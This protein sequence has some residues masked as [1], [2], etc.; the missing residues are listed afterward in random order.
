M[1][2][3]RIVPRLLLPG[4]AVLSL[5]ACMHG[6][7]RPATLDLSRSRLTTHGTYRATIRPEQDTIPQG[8]LHRWILTL[9]TPDGAAVDGATV[10]INGGMPEHGHGLPT[11]PRVTRA[12]GN[13]EHLVEGVK[14]SMRGWWELRFAISTAAGA[15]TVTFNLDL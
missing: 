13:G 8:R 6:Q 9:Q 5:T 4:L 12:L 14:F 11:T 2:T 3:S 1:S 10:A 15:D 7:A